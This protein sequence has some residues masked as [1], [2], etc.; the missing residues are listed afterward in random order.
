MRLFES[1]LN[2]SAKSQSHLFPRKRAGAGSALFKELPL[3]LRSFSRLM[4][5]FHGRPFQI[6]ACHRILTARFI[7]SKIRLGT[8]GRAGAA[9]ER[10]RIFPSCRGRAGVSFVPRKRK[11][12]MGIIGKTLF[13][14][15]SRIPD[16][17][18][19][20]GNVRPRAISRGHTA[21]VEVSHLQAAL[22]INS[23][24]VSWLRR[25]SK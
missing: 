25:V 23:A 10:G 1:R 24:R 6:I 11:E 14:F 8:G 3:P 17:L 2:A 9:K 12:F 22:I 16:A 5:I 21:P 19:G 15:S 4:A 18:R 13:S 20:K 7:R